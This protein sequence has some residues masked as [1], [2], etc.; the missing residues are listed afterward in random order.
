MQQKLTRKDVNKKQKNFLYRMRNYRIRE[1]K[2]MKE[3]IGIYNQEI[4]VIDD[5]IRKFKQI[6]GELE[7]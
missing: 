6:D 2:L 5:R 4:D 7:G 1:I 3:K